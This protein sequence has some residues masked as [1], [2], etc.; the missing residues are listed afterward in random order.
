MKTKEFV[1][2]VKSLGYDVEE[3]ADMIHIQKDVRINTIASI[4]KIKEFTFEVK[5]DDWEFY[6]IN[7]RYQ[8]LSCIGAYVSTP[9]K[10]REKLTKYYLRLKGTEIPSFPNAVY[11]SFK[12]GSGYYFSSNRD[13]TEIYKTIFTQKE[14]D[15]LP[16][17]LV[18][19]FDKVEVQDD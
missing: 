16:R 7:E 2:R 12:R 10:E 18:Q 5:V 3:F 9:L 8:L 1:T 13:N 17:R 19:S 4:S 11:L 15:K 6:D 14:I